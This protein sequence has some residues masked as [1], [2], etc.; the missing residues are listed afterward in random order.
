MNRAYLIQFDTTWTLVTNR[1]L[2][3]IELGI[4]KWN[5]S[6]CMSCWFTTL[7]QIFTFVFVHPALEVTDLTM[8]SVKS[9]YGTQD[10]GNLHDCCSGPA[11]LNVLMY[12]MYMYTPKFAVVCFA[13]QPDK[14]NSFHVC[15]SKWKKNWC[16]LWQCH[17]FLSTRVNS[18]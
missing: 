13:N 11:F 17:W 1:Q 9:Q 3:L 12:S 6:A 10:N 5:H 7:Y 8:H 2:A 15:E 4:E 16:A 14:K 18:L